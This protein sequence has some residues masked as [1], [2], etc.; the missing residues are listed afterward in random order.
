M[1]IRQD[2]LSATGYDRQYDVPT[3]RRLLVTVVN[4]T[5]SHVLGG[6]A[7]RRVNNSSNLI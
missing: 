4:L 1:Y 5:R 6:G 7:L 3:I 2:A